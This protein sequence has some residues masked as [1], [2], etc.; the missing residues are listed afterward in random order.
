MKIDWLNSAGFF[1]L[2]LKIPYSIHK[3]LGYS[4]LYS[5]I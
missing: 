3:I 1:C 4:L 2:Y 5:L